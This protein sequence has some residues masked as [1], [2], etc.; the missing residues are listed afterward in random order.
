[1]SYRV[2]N[3]KS[4]RLELLYKFYNHKDWCEINRFYWQFV[5]MAFFFFFFI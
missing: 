5:Q 2:T 4:E 3:I 1:M